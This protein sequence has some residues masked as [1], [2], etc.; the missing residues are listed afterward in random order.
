MYGLEIR[1][2]GVCSFH[3]GHTGKLSTSVTLG[4]SLSVSVLPSESS[5]RVRTSWGCDDSMHHGILEGVV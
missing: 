4:S 3:G 1:N 5:V 2:V